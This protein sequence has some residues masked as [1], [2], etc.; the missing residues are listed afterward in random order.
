MT[1]AAI[2]PRE[3]VRFRDVDIVFD[4]AALSVH[5]LATG[6]SALMDRTPD[7]PL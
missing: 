2:P 6:V 7:R 1:A 4:A 5:A 3:V